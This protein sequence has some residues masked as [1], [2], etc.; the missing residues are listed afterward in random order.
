MWRS[1]PP[2]GPCG[3]SHL[4]GRKKKK[5]TRFPLRHHPHYQSRATELNHLCHRSAL[6]GRSNP[7]A[8][9]L[10]AS[11]PKFHIAT[12]S[13]LSNSAYK[14][15]AKQTHKHSIN[16]TRRHSPRKPGSCGEEKERCF[17][18]YYI[19]GTRLHHPEKDSEGCH[20][21]RKWLYFY[22]KDWQNG[23][24]YTFCQSGLAAGSDVR[25]A[26]TRVTPYLPH[27]T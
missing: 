4:K 9:A 7:R 26:K 2:R 17:R 14:L 11:N 20:R 5:K 13:A 3:Y 19:R 15:E 10:V 25:L 12:C 1:P 16:L 22:P 18:R 23:R 24:K 6:R 21:A 27:G 8:G